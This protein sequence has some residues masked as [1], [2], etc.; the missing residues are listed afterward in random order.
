MHDMNV[1]RAAASRTPKRIPSLEVPL[2]SKRRLRTLRMHDWQRGERSPQVYPRLSARYQTLFERF[3]RRYFR[4]RLPDYRV[5]VVASLLDDCDLGLCDVRQKSIT[6]VNQAPRDLLETLVHEMAHAAVRSRGYQH[7]TWPWRKELERLRRAGAPVEELHLPT[8][9]T[10]SK[11]FVRE[12]AETV[13]SGNP[14]ITPSRYVRFLN[15]RIGLAPSVTVLL[16]RHPWVP[17][18][19]KKTRSRLRRETFRQRCV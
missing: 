5:E 17:A 14:K 3:N 2:L 13:L 1:R 8:L 9:E 18:L 16:R 15:R 7:H 6:L 10:L 19:F 11:H 4:G 12:H